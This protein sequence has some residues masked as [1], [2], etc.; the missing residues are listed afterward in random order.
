MSLRCEQ[1]RIAAE[2]IL[3][4]GERLPSADAQLHDLERDRRVELRNIPVMGATR[5]TAAIPGT[6][7]LAALLAREARA[8]R[9]P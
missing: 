5:V 1:A 6:D 7:P 8:T 9:R 3:E 2:A 4:T